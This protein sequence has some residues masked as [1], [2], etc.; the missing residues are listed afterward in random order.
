MTP[1]QLTKTLSTIFTSNSKVPPF[2]WGPAGVGKSAIVAQVAARFD[3]EVVDLR[4]GQIP[5]SDLRGL[6]YVNNGK[7]CY[8]RPEWLRSE[9]KGV[10]FLDELPNAVPTVQGL[11][12]QLLL[13]RR[14]GEH[15]LGDGW[16]VVGAGNRRQDGA[17]VHAM[18]SPVA[19]RLMHLTL[20]P[21]LDSWKAYAVSAGLHPNIVGFLCFRPELLFC[22]ERQLTAFPSPRSWEMAS[23]LVKIGLDI[24]SCVGDAAAGEFNAYREMVADIPDLELILAGA[25]KDIEFPVE[26]SAQ[27]ATCVGLAM[28]L[29]DA[30]QAL[31]AF[32]WL[33]DRVGPEW[34]QMFIA[35]SMTRLKRLDCFGPFAAMIPGHP[36]LA[37]FVNQAIKV[38][39]A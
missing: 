13:D 17:S 29:N 20:E 23:E 25:A 39:A 33:D 28:S 8:A 9:G 10:L 30:D 22:F 34:L 12:Q 4:M 18:P 16:F 6:P 37:S 15:S 14:I 3:L 35:D 19:N 21:H 31:R 26:M 27:Y 5:P 2:I 38:V 11:C 1:E 7:S 36:R 24:G 32:E